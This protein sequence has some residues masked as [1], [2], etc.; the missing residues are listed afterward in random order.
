MLLKTAR[1]GSGGL[2]LGRAS[3]GSVTCVPDIVGHP[4]GRTPA[5]QRSYSPPRLVASSSISWVSSFIVAPSSG[6]SSSGAV[7]GSPVS[8]GVAL[9]SSWITSSSFCVPGA[10]SSS[11]VS[12]C[13]CSVCSLSGLSSSV[14]QALRVSA[15]NPAPSRAMSLS[16]D[17][18]TVFLQLCFIRR[19][20]ACSQH[21]LVLSTTRGT[22]VVNAIYA[23]DPWAADYAKEAAPDRGGQVLRGHYAEPIL[24]CSQVRCLLLCRSGT[25]PS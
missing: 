20:S 5:L 12:N 17:V 16:F 15:R 24:G 13:S 14:P 4:L 6:S 22:S 9:C 19:H 18:L 23:T 8:C 7:S 3:A 25:E 2:R 1:P 21:F 10:G 11:N